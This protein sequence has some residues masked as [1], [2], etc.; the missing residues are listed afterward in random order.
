MGLRVISALRWLN[1]PT[2]FK[3]KITREYSNLYTANLHDAATARWLVG[4]T[5]VDAWI[6]G[7]LSNGIG[8][9]KIAV[10]AYPVKNSDRY[11]EFDTSVP[12]N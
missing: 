1:R 4:Q 10:D 5:E 2:A 9:L 12:L 7:T 6:H 11:F 8:G 3:S